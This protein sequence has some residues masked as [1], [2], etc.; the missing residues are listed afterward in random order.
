[1]ASRNSISNR[2]WLDPP[3]P[4]RRLRLA[5]GVA[6]AASLLATVVIAVLA[7]H[8]LDLV[9]AGMVV[10]P[11]TVVAYLA[12]WAVDLVAFFTEPDGPDW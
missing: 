6:V 4:L 12:V 11:L 7:T 8:R 3:G 1:M 9:L 5:I 2:T 10:T